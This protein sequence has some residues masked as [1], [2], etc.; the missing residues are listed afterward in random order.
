[1]E[2]SK[3]SSCLVFDMALDIDTSITNTFAET[4]F[5]AGS[6]SCFKQTRSLCHLFEELLCLDKF[7]NVA[8]LV[9]W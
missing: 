4:M 3:C 2:L 7:P 9:M 5:V 6:Y 1:M 8:W